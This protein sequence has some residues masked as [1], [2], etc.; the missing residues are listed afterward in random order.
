MNERVKGGEDGNMEAWLTGR[1][2]EEHLNRT[3]GE[4]PVG[5][6][7]EL[8]EKLLDDVGSKGYYQNRFNII[9]N[10][11]LITLFAMPFI[12][13]IMVMTVPDHWCFVPGRKDYNLTL[14]QWKNIFI[15]REDGTNGEGSGYKKCQMYN[16]TASEVMDLSKTGLN[17]TLRRNDVQIIE[18]QY[19]W[20]YD[21]TWYKG[22]APSDA[23]WVCDKELYV[24]NCFAVARIGDVLGTMILGQLGDIIGRK[25]VFL[26]SLTVVVI[27]RSFVSLTTSIF[28]LFT[29]LILM[30]N[31]CSNAVFQ[32]PLAIGMEVSSSTLH[33]R[34]NGVQY[35][36]WTIGVSALPF[37]AWICSDWKLLVLI[38]S[39]PA[40][41]FLLLHRM[42]PESPR[43]L[44]AKNR[45]EEAS[46][47]LM[48]IARINKRELPNDCMEKLKHIA[49]VSRKQKCYGLI[50]LF[51]SKRLAFHTILIM[52][53]WIVTPLCYDVIL[54]NVS[55]LS[56][57]PFLNFFYQSIVE[58]PGYI[59]G[60]WITERFGRRWMHVAFLLLNTLTC[61][62]ITLVISYYDENWL[63]ITLVMFSKFCTSLNFY[64]IYLQALEI[65]PTCLRQTGSSA[66][67]I[68]ASLFG[69]LGPFV[70]YLGTSVDKR[71]PYVIMGG[72]CIV[73]AIAASFL[74]ETL[75]QQLPETLAEA[76]VFGR[77]QR[78][79]SIVTNFR[80]RRQR[81]AVSHDLELKENS[82]DDAG[83]S[84]TLS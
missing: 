61:S 81:R 57:N 29:L 2:E 13:Y 60:M 47:V 33:S 71:Y 42:I 10:F 25:P 55:H 41:F 23:N 50:S 8:F 9:F 46:K 31:S 6:E 54:L 1:H 59:V 78:Y 53:C 11:A 39:L 68:T 3:E 73:G 30:A 17:N 62:C 66:G 80:D 4:F 64:I 19:G 70:V 74:P 63:S 48:E 7:A 44:A 65:Y 32:S 24:T 69:V 58:L 34:I 67:L 14:E 37:I 83:E 12:N 5:T 36:G 35:V 56:G 49:E 43:W 28:P 27:G 82:P 16:L 72:I 38:T 75:Q 52:I 22:T 77:N 76:Q 84:H 26:L 20:E 18:C 79:W 40:G 45:P 15:P 21:T 51:S